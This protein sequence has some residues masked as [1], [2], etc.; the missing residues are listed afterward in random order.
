VL[1]ADGQLLAAASRSGSTPGSGVRGEADPETWLHDA[2]AAACDAVGASPVQPSIISVSALGPAPVLLDGRGRPVGPAL[3]YR[4]DTRS[5]PQRAR[6]AMGLGEDAAPGPDH[7]LPKLLWWHDERPADFAR[8]VVVVDAA[9]FVGAA[10]SGVVAMDEVTFSD[11]YT[12][13]RVPAP[14]MI[15][16]RR[17]PLSILGGL[18]P[19][20]ASQLGLPSGLP[21][22]VGTIDSYADLF[23]AGV[24]GP[25]DAALVLGSTTVAAVASGDPHAA[26]VGVSAGSHLGGGRLLSAW[27]SAAGTALDSAATLVGI[28]R[29]YNHDR[30]LAALAPGAG[31]LLAVAPATLR[32][33]TPATAPGAL[34]GVSAKTT[35][36]E[37]LR[38]YVD[39]VAIGVRGLARR[40]SPLVDNVAWFAWGGL[41][42]SPVFTQ[43]VADAVG[44]PLL[45]PRHAHC[46][47]GPAV[48]GLH[49]LGQPVHLATITTI[50]PSTSRAEAYATLERKLLALQQDLDGICL[51]GRPRLDHTH[52]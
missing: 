20:V 3:L 24:R 23:A 46:G 16:P 2:L 50:A 4:L 28:P 51:P 36:L 27:T 41:T 18:G 33:D 29:W 11:Y 10:L 43:A 7:A 1:D 52:P 15:A 48:L 12:L 26:T 44:R 22:A 14:I 40:L 6:L 34:I 39:A 9:G 45:I 21:V 8:A 17:P 31:G 42:R 32:A 47:V 49:A 19:R 37:V 25:G 35:P 38:A 13:P 30:D 5:E